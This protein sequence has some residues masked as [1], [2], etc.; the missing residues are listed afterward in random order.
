MATL[1]LDAATIPLHMC[2]DAGQG[3]RPARRLEMGPARFGRHAS[4]GGRAAGLRPAAAGVEP[5]AGADD[6]RRTRP[7][8]RKASR[9]AKAARTAA[10]SAKAAGKAARTT[11]AASAGARAGKGARAPAASAGARPAKTGG[12]GQA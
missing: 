8:A 2:P 9:K 5:G 7:A 6:Q 12:G 1:V 10:G 11:K 3:R 4:G